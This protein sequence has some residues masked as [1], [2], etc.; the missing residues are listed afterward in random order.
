MRKGSLELQHRSANLVSDRS[1]A[2]LMNDWLSSAAISSPSRSSGGGCIVGVA[3]ASM[4]AST[5][6]NLN[7]CLRRSSIRVGAS[8]TGHESG[9]GRSGLDHVVTSG[10]HMHLDS[11]CWVGIW[12][13]CC[14]GVGIWCVALKL[15]SV[16]GGNVVC[17]WKVD[18]GLD[19][20]GY[21]EI[22]SLQSG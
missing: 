12:I 5:G 17:G 18:R 11:L 2:S 8:K 10:S 22:C 15:D 9:F 21:I 7:G 16:V 14:F 4:M 20:V 3:D 1:M 13:I 6:L 19:M